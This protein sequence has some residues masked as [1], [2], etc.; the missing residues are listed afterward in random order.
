M[1]CHAPD[2][3]GCCTRS[4]NPVVLGAAPALLLDGLLCSGDD[5]EACCNAPAYGDT[6]IASGRLERAQAE[7]DA[8]LSG[9][10]LTS[11]TLCKPLSSTH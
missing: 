5:S 4:S 3:I 2:G 7:H 1:D 11:V 6:L 8:E 9:Y 10:T